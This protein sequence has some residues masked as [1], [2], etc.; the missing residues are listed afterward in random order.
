MNQK[1]YL[2]YVAQF[3][4]QIDNLCQF[5][6]QDRVQDFAKMNAHEILL[7]T[8]KSVCSI[9]MMEMFKQ[10][11]ALKD[12]WNNSEIELAENRKRLIEISRRNDD[13]RAKL[14]K[15]KEINDLTAEINICNSKKAWIEFEALYLQCKALEKD[16]ALGKKA[17]ADHESVL[18]TNESHRTEYINKKKYFEEKI[19]M[20]NSMIVKLKLDVSNFESQFEKL[21]DE[22]NR[23]AA[24]L[25][26]IVLSAQ[27]QGKEITENEKLLSV[28][29][30]DLEKAET[31]VGN[32][33]G[34]E[35][36]IVFL[37]KSFII[38][39]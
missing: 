38:I 7:N 2:S 16:L 27:D 22:I 37:F 1:E 28:Y 36:Y 19:A 17:L 5:L 23:T 15:L 14:E 8:Q 20:H 32:L 25:R 30:F 3:N 12:Q 26:G 24:H 9:E 6:P 10:L 29:I 31:E 4:I 11:I 13:I 18:A 33:D 21:E 34:N 39:M 35:I